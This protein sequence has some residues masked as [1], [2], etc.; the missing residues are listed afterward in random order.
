MITF[1]GGVHPVCACG[2]G[3]PVKFYEK[4]FEFSWYMR[5][6]SR[7]SRGVGRKLSEETKNLIGMK[8]RGRKVSTEA[9]ENMRQAQF[10]RYKNDPEARLQA[11]RGGK[12]RKMTPE[13]CKKY[14]DVNNRRW[15]KLDKEQRKLALIKLHSC[16]QS[17]RQTETY[18]EACSIAQKK[19]FSDPSEREKY[20]I[21][22]SGE[23]NP[24]WNGN[25]ET[26]DERQRFIVEMRTAFKK[27]KKTI[28][29]GHLDDVVRELG[30]TGRQF[31]E[32]VERQFTDGMSWK[33]WGEWHVDHVVPV[34]R[35]SIGS[36]ASEVNALPNL[37]PLWK[38]DN[39]SKAD[40]LD[41]E[42]CR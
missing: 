19:R 2:C 32:H 31:K 29:N 13:L 16:D 27:V 41:E 37:R 11:A 22:M 42:I 33:N 35:W 12:N 10:A 39:L 7:V 36:S 26:L 30:Y 28:F 20:S 17:Y 40:R 34:S 23:N 3:K 38:F 21:A 8:N 4:T 1:R 9:R 18:R 6:H 5:G 24:R 25:R 14:S 15:S